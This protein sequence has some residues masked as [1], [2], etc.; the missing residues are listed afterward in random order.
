MNPRKSAAAARALIDAGEKRIGVMACTGASSATS[1]SFCRSPPDS[2]RRIEP[3][4]FGRLAGHQ[5][6]SRFS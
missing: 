6:A 4:T 2:S 3:T 1:V 5:P